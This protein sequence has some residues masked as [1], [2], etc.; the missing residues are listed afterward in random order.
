M[1]AADRVAETLE[2]AQIDDEI[3]SL[4]RR[5]VVVAELRVQAQEAESFVAARGL[6]VSE[7]DLTDRI[8]AVRSARAEAGA[9]DPAQL[10]LAIIESLRV[11]PPSLRQQVAAGLAPNIRADFAS[12]SRLH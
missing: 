12:P 11:M 2:I 1:T 7:L 10:I 5:L 9:E 3:E 6:L 4:E 8:R